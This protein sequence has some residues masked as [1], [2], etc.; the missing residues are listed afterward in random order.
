MPDI[1]DL[2]NKVIKYIDVCDTLNTDIAGNSVDSSN[3]GFINLIEKDTSNLKINDLSLSMLAL[4]QNQGNR[5]KINFKV[6]LVNSYIEWKGEV[7]PTKCIY[8]VFWFDEPKTMNAIN[9]D[10][11]CID[12]FEIPINAANVREV[13][14]RENRTLYQKKF[15]NLLLLASDSLGMITPE[16]RTSITEYQSSKVFIT[17][18]L[19]NYAYVRD[20]PIYLFNQQNVR[21]EIRLQNIVFDFTNSYLRFPPNTDLSNTSVCFNAVYSND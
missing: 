9:S 1:Y 20:V 5:Y 10:N 3:N 11:V 21:N 18:Q 16:N 2:K 4:S 7:D 14:L 12:S 15:R 19:N 6:D 17:L 13:M 8:L